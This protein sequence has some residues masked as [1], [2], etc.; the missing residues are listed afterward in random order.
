WLASSYPQVR[1]LGILRLV[2]DVMQV[3][4]LVTFDNTGRL[5]RIAFNT[6]DPL[7]TKLAN[8]WQPVLAP[9]GITITLADLQVIV[10]NP[11]V[12]MH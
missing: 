4:G 11:S 6:L 10:N 7:A 1:D 2:R 9:L 8:A 12:K 5:I 3:P